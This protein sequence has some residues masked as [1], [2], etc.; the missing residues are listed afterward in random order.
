MLIYKGE[1]KID[2]KE[3]IT[4]DE[5]IY[6]NEIKIEDKKSFM[7]PDTQKQKKKSFHRQRKEERKK[8]AFSKKFIITI[9][10]EEKKEKKE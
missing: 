9:S 8:K 5:S 7:T 10:Q 2:E 4:L 1:K 3:T 6:D